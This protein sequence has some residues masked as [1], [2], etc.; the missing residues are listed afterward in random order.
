VSS[1]IFQVRL[2]EEGFRNY[3][4]GIM[5]GFS[6]GINQYLPAFEKLGFNAPKPFI[7]IIQF[8]FEVSTKCKEHVVNV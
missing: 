4:N 1:F 6:P 5:R 8:Q 7:I 3:F 2:T